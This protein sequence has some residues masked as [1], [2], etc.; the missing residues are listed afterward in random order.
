[1]LAEIWFANAFCF[2]AIAMVLVAALCSA[3]GLKEQKRTLKVDDGSTERA[4]H[5]E[6]YAY[7]EQAWGR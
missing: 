5:Y 4:K 1:M 3:K 6:Q 7:V 2:S